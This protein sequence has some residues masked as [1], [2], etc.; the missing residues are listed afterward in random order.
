MNFDSGRR[1]QWGAAER[2]KTGLAADEKSVSG[3]SLNFRY[4]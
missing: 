1:I 2:Y 3:F 4:K